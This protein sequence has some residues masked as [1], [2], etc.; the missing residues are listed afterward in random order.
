M[1][2][3]ISQVTREITLL[4]VAHSLLL[5]VVKELKHVER[6]ERSQSHDDAGSG[7]NNPE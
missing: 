6:K 2:K 5:E 7:H 1:K 3:V 4:E